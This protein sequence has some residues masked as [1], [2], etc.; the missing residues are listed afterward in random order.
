[1]LTE[2]NARIAQTLSKTSHLIKDPKNWTKD[3]YAKNKNNEEVSPEDPTAVKYSLMGAVWKVCKT[4]FINSKH[5]AEITQNHI[6]EMLEKE[7]LH[8]NTE[9]FNDAPGTTHQD[10]IHILKKTITNLMS[11]DTQIKEFLSLALETIK[12]PKNWTKGAMVRDENDTSLRLITHE[13]TA[14]TKYC[15][16]GALRKNLNKMNTAEINQLAFAEEKI[17]E[18]INET[19]KDKSEIGDFNGDTIEAFNDDPKTTH[20]DVIHILKETIEKW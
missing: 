3:T 5:H 7:N 1:M 8:E 2:R 10:V 16:I 19:V 6:E 11:T 4:D 20:E 15:L 17:L 18:T 14:T 9:D 12:D 13:P